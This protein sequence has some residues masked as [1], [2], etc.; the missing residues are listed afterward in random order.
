M[1]YW[2]TSPRSRPSNGATASKLGFSTSSRAMQSVNELWVRPMA[3]R[4][5]LR[6]AVHGGSQSNRRT[7]GGLVQVSPRCAG[8]RVAIEQHTG[9]QNPR[10]FYA[11]SFPPDSR[12]SFGAAATDHDGAASP[13]EYQGDQPLQ[14]RPDRYPFLSAKD[15]RPSIHSKTEQV[16]TGHSDQDLVA[17]T[18]KDVPKPSRARG[19][20]N[21]PR[22]SE[23]W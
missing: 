14:R 12:N 19:P 11:T 15:E 10:V 9:R 20:T 21:G 18:T 16:L 1:A 2:A 23:A 7:T 5:D 22:G 4:G 6:H 17:I 3:Y 8:P 13:R